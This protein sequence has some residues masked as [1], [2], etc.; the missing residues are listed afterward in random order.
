ME[1]LMDVFR[2]EYNKDKQ[3]LDKKVLATLRKK[4][5]RMK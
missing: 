1:E 3:E 5:S 4:K 2:N